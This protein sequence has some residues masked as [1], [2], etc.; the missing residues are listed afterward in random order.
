MNNDIV[1]E[2]DVW[3]KSVCFQKPTTEAYDLAKSAW[4]KQAATIEELQREDKQILSHTAELAQAE[5]DLKDKITKLEAVLGLPS[6]YRVAKKA[7]QYF[8]TEYMG[9]EPKQL[10]EWALDEA[11]SELGGEG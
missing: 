5:V 9:Q 1:K 7:I 3:L 11:L 8:D 10:W 6:T 4:L 2:F